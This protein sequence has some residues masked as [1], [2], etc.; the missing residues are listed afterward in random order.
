[1][2]VKIR[3]YL[4]MNNCIAVVRLFLV[5]FDQRK[6]NQNLLPTKDYYS[7]EIFENLLEKKKLA[8]SILQKKTNDDP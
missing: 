2:I 3:K 7:T 8:Q 1:M 5:V 4:I 6:G